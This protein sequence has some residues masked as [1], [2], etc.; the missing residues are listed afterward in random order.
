MTRDEYSGALK[1]LE[2]MEVCR[3]L[4]M[5]SD[6]SVSCEFYTDIREKTRW[7]TVQT[8]LVDEKSVLCFSSIGPCPQDA[9]ILSRLL[10]ENLDGEF[11]RLAVLDGDL[12]QIYRHRIELIEPWI[13]YKAMDEV[14]QLANYAWRRYFGSE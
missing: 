3:S 8:M 6:T 12:I 14:S 2:Q 10:V 4:D 5:T 13:L 7:Q 9:E 11:S 1:A